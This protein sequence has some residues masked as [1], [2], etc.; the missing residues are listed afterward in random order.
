[1]H[2]VPA[3]RADHRTIDG[4]RVCDAVEAIGDV[5]R[6]REWAERFSLLAD[7]HRLALLLALRRVGPL[8]V[9]DLAVASGMNGA[10]VSQALR[11]LRAAGVVAGE[12]TGRVVRYRLVDAEIGELVDAVGT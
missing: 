8:A 4:H 7:P 11:L 10:A 6:V 12:K 5:A 1:M 2:L 3:E 9:S